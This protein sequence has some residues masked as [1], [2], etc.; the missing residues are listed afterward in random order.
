[1]A[2]SAGIGLRLISAP[3]WEPVVP[4]DFV[5]HSRIANSDIDNGVVQSFI[6]AARDYI[7]TAT[8]RKIA[9]Q[10]WLLCLDYWPGIFIDD[11]R[12]TAWRYGI[13][14]LPFPPLISVDIVQYVQPS[15]SQQAQ[16][17]PLT[18]L[19]PSMYMVKTSAEPG[20]LAPS[21][22][23]IWPI[24][25]PMAFEAVQ[26]TFTC[27]Y[28]TKDAVP[29]GVVQAIKLLTAHFYENREE[30]TEKALKRIPLGIKALISANEAHECC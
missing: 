14:R 16:P 13:V 23:N 1:M 30:T 24:T 21:L 17:F 12:P 10:Q 4:G 25:H 9:Q 27:G 3:T 22:Y 18:T 19:D 5:N 2:G 8:K 28:A 15:V 6:L 26:I 20:L 7:E 11:W 29:P